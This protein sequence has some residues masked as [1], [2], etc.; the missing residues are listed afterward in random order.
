MV[1]GDV[2]IGKR[3]TVGAAINSVAATLAHYYPEHAPAIV[4]VAVPLTFVAQ[5]LI[6][7]YGGI[8]LNPEGK[9]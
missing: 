5:I 7:R 4:S 1:L 9:K 6:A 2:V 3:V 8:T